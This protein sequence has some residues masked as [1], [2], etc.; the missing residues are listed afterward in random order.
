MEALKRLLPKKVYLKHC[1]IVKLLC[2]GDFS[3]D[4]LALEF[5]RA[6]TELCEI[7][8]GLAVMSTIKFI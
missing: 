6:K 8:V 2:S 5:F 4:I 7:P 3:M 1:D